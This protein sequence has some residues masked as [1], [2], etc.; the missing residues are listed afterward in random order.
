M[1]LICRLLFIY[2]D[3]LIDSSWHYLHLRVELLRDCR[4]A[5]Q[6]RGL[7]SLVQPLIEGGSRQ[8]RGVGTAKLI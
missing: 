1:I 4:D 6:R 3:S 7:V 5:K 2:E 8:S